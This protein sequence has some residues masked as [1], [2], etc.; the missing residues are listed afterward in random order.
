MEI[1]KYGNMEILKYGKREIW[2]YGKMG[3]CEYGNMEI[4]KKNPHMEENNM[5]MQ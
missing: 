3:I 4:W 2:K 5:F 1:W